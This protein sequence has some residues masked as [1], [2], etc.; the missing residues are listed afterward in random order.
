MVLRS[1]CSKL[2]KEMVGAEYTVA[3]Q[4]S[5]GGLSSASWASA[6]SVG[7]LAMR[8]TV[9]TLS[10]PQGQGGS[11]TCGI[12]A[13]LVFLLHLTH[14]LPTPPAPSRSLRPGA[15]GEVAA[16]DLTLAELFRPL[17]PRPP[18]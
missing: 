13:C 11:L 18:T 2:K 4:G 14:S 10:L 17:P 15:H 7:I 12:K 6:S 1:E 5:E 3:G 16:V 9:G 8:V